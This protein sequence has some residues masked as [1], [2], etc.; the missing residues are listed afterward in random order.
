MLPTAIFGKIAEEANRY[1]QQTAERTGQPDADW[2]PTNEREVKAYFGLWILMGINQLPDIHMYWSDNK[3]IGH[4]GFKECMTRNTF[5]KLSQHLHLNNNTT[6]GPP[7]SPL[8][9]KSST[10]A[11]NSLTPV[12]FLLVHVDSSS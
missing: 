10:Q 12:H 2:T 9:D 4:Q 8:Y 11:I 3:Y 1:A 5:I 6:Q 7:G